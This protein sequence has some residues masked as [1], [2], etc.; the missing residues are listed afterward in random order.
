MLVK[1]NVFNHVHNN[2]SMILYLM[3]NISVLINAH[4]IKN[5]CNYY[6]KEKLIQ[7]NYNVLLLMFVIKKVNMFILKIRDVKMLA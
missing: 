3:I 6:I 5:I 7:I 4:K 2:N 1:N